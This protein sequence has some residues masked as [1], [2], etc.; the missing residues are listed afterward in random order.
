MGL[1]EH[2]SFGIKSTLSTLELSE[3]YT[4]PFRRTITPEDES[5]PIASEMSACSSEGR[6]KATLKRE[7]TV[8]WR[9]AGSPNYHGD[10]VDS[11]Q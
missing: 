1:E 3:L 2:V 5:F 9:E 11:D 7:Y 6:C 8:P 10:K 4:S